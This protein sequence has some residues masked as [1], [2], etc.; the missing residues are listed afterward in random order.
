MEP[1]KKERSKLLEIIKYAFIFYST[2]MPLVNTQCMAKSVRTSDHYN[3][4]R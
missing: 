3:H 1:I 4:I 2:W